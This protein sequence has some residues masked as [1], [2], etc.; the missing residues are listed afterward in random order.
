MRFGKRF[1]ALALALLL[2]LALAPAAEAQT[3]TLVKNSGTL[4][5]TAD[6]VDCEVEELTSEQYVVKIKNIKAHQLSHKYTIVF[7]TKNGS[8]TVTGSGLS[9]VH[10]M[11]ILCKNNPAGQNAAVALYRYSEY[12]DALK[13]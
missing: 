6:G 2:M 1:S 3:G 11:F 10:T 8:M 13:R 5:A 4:T 12:A 7:M 9:Y